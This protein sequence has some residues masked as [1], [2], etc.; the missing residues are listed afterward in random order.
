MATTGD[1]GAETRFSL[2]RK[3]IALERKKGHDD[4]AAIGGMES[5]LRQHLSEAGALVSGYGQFTPEH[6]AQVLDDVEALIINLES[7][8]SPPRSLDVPIEGAVGVGPR[9]GELLRKLGI[10]TVE[11]LLVFFPRRLEDR[12][13]RSTIGRLSDGQAA[14]VTGRVRAK[15]RVRVRRGLELI[16]VAIE[17]GTGLLFAVWFNQ[18]WLWDEM[19]QGMDLALFGKAQIRY[20][21]LQVENPIWERD[22]AG[23]HTGRWVPLY[24][25]TEGLTQPMLRSLIL[26]NLERFG[27]ALPELIPRDVRQ[28]I[29]LMERQRAVQSIHFPDD[30]DA[31]RHARRTLAFEELLLLQIGLANRSLPDR[32]GRVLE[33]DQ[34]LTARFVEDLPFALTPSQ[35][36]ALEEIQRDLTA[37]R[38]MWRLLQG[39]VGSGKTVVA[40]GAAVAA[41]SA[42]AQVAVMAPTEIL[43][44]QHYLV[45]RQLLGG[46]PVEVALLVGRIPARERS[47]TL[48]QLASGEIHVVVGTH[49]LIQQDVAF[50]ELGLAVIDE[51]HRFGVVQRSTLE[52]KGSGV[53]I[54]VMSATPIPRT[55]V[56]TVYGSF[57]V[58]VLQEMPRGRAGVRTVW[59]SESRRNDVYREI[60]AWLERGGSGY[61]VF[62]LVEES[63]EL[64]LRDASRAYA[65]LS[66]RFPGVGVGLLHGR[67]KPDEKRTAMEAFRE[68]TTRVLVATSIVEV[69][70]DVP[71]ASFLVI[72][73]ADRFGLAQLHQLR[74]RIGRAGQEACC[75][76][77]ADPTTDDARK[78]MVAFRDMTD[79]LRIAEEDLRIRGPGDLLGTAQHGFVSR[80]RVADLIRDLGLLERAQSEA[81]A[82][83]DE[84]R[85]ADLAE[86][87]KRRFGDSIELLGV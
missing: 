10:E 42:G 15:S 57:S 3:V 75:Y 87:A 27:S 74:G 24:P 81:R 29:G 51:Q 35:F 2:V 83:V 49:A 45:L 11:D 53:N 55:I 64:D 84:G 19:H 70:L 41:I 7:G 32:Q 34:D 56:L 6:R 61:V 63:E 79:G 22:G 30:P 14:T 50:A 58:S 26:R 36:R 38:P 8:A 72:E 48:E 73:H 9:R 69:G 78:R 43:A 1:R 68:G 5:F 16:K 28:R 40:A 12:T 17:D 39:D 82:L 13:A 85:A 59:M 71:D 47:A 77:I 62:P 86:E 46:L 18:P 80:L 60:A 76:A 31:F 23:L 65:E 20:G 21:E 33:L 54:L 25:A 66:A 44:E 52:E 67:M 37:P 4:T